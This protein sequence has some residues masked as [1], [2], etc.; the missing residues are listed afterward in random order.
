ML[1][2]SVLLN[3]KQP[4][5][6][7]AFMLS[8]VS[9]SMRGLCSISRDPQESDMTRGIELLTIDWVENHT[10]TMREHL[11]NNVGVTVG[12]PTSSFF[13]RTSGKDK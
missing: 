5:S 4:W 8:V 13:P 6:H 9:G 7:A 10:S 1:K 3:H 2:P 11:Q 12:Q